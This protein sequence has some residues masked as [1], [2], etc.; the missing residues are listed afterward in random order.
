MIR[1]ANAGDVG[2]GGRSIEPSLG[3]PGG[4]G[5]IR[6]DEIVLWSSGVVLQNSKSHVSSV[7]L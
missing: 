4:Q 6:I 2:E 7:N 5:L 1:C 3:R